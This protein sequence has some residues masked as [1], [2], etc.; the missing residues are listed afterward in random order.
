LERKQRRKQRP[1]GDEKLGEE[2]QRAR[3]EAG[4][5]QPD[6]A[7]VLGFKSTGDISDI[8]TGKVGLSEE[9]WKTAFNYLERVAEFH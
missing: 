6:L 3:E 4:L 1:P 8:E 9:E 7:P 5:T 2:L